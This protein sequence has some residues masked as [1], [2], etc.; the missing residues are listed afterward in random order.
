MAGL[1]LWGTSRR[2]CDRLNSGS[3]SFQPGQDCF[4]VGPVFEAIDFRKPRE[5]GSTPEGGMVNPVDSFKPDRFFVDGQDKAAG[6]A[7]HLMAGA[8]RVDAEGPG[9]HDAEFVPLAASKDKDVLVAVM[10]VPRDT[11]GFMVAEQGGG[12]S[13]QAVAVET[14]NVHPLAEGLPIQLIRLFG[15]KEEVGELDDGA[16]GSGEIHKRRGVQGPPG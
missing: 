16:G 2:S 6:F 5:G 3:P 14:I 8:G 11:A 7:H 10:M 4:P 9:R 15:K 13:G 12:R 1:A